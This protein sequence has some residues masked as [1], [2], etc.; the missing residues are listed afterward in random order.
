M[1]DAYDALEQ[2]DLEMSEFLLQFQEYASYQ[3]K[4]DTQLIRDCT[5]KLNG[6]MKQWAQNLDRKMINWS[7]F[8]KRL[9]EVDEV[10]KVEK[11]RRQQ[12]ELKRVPARATK[13]MPTPVVTPKLQIFK[14]VASDVKDRQ[15]KMDNGT[16]T[17]FNCHK[18]GHLSR[19]CPE[20]KKPY[21]PPARR[22]AARIQ[23]IHGNSDDD[24]D[25]TTVNDS[26]EPLSDSEN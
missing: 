15:Q 1:L 25:E 23:A 14:T 19:D 12:R 17:C 20:P 9:I 7:L 3:T 21:S 4:T 16:G 11:T 2:D 22:E 8:R 24:Q 5:N 6:R 26:D 18:P 10:H 13:V